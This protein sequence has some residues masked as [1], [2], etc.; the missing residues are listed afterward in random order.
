MEFQAIIMAAGRGSRMSDLTS[1]MPKALLPVA[2]RPLV[3]YPVNMLETSGFSE[4]T[5][6]VCETD[7]QSILKTLEQI[8]DVKIKLHFVSIPYEEDWG[9]LDSLRHIADQIKSDLLVVSCD[10]ICSVQL[11][12]MADLHRTR[13][14]ALTMLLAPSPDVSEASVPGGKA[15]RKVEHDV[16]G[17]SP[18]N[19]L[20][21]ISSEADLEQTLTFK[22]SFLKKFPMVRLKNRVMD[23]H[24]YFMKRSLLDHAC[25]G[26]LSTST[27]IKGEFIPHLVRRQFRRRHCAKDQDQ[28]LNM[29]ADV[30]QDGGEN[31]D[32]FSRLVQ[33][34]STHPNDSA[35]MRDCFHGDR[36]KCY[37]IMVKDE[38]CVRVNTLVSYC[39]AN[40]QMA[41]ELA[42]VGVL[43][44]PLVAPSVQIP[45]K[46]T[47]G[48]DSLMAEGSSVGERSGIKRSVI[49][50]HCVIGDHVKITNCIIMNHVT[51]EEGS[52]L[53]GTVVCSEARLGAKCELKDCLVT[54]GQS[55]IGKSTNEVI[56]NLEQLMEV[57]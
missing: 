2:N 42:R 15:N 34:Y 35:S 54:G 41:K 23:A 30:R 22:H 27:T 37:A 47:V 14:A 46:S 45:S 6:V 38:L 19:R 31:E 20:L 55:V 24:L 29:T 11:H 56:V 36:M 25:D 48:A 40:R 1:C 18:D 57:E 49:G 9:T 7:L 3:W 28:S 17:L 53:S 39:E 4:A 12:Q 32:G 43:D 33:E 26:A 5:I 50:K 21:F 8:C 10:L 16:V 44:E 51:I 52:T 13:D